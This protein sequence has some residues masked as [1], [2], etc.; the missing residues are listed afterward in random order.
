MSVY[1]I[2]QLE[3]LGSL[4]S[5]HRNARYKQRL[6]QNLHVEKELGHGD[7]FRFNCVFFLK[8]NHSGSTLACSTSQSQVDIWNPAMGKLLHSLDG[9]REIVTS[10][11]WLKEDSTDA[12]FSASLDK[13]IRLWRH[14]KPVHVLR[15]HR[16][17]IRSLGLSR[18]NKTLVSGCVSSKILGWDV[19]SCK[20]IFRLDHAEHRQGQADLNTVNSL[21]FSHHSS[22]LFASG[23]RDG[24]AMLWDIRTPVKP[25]LQFR[26]HKNKLNSVCFSADDLHLLTS[27]R[28]SAIRLWDIRCTPTS[29]PL[30][31]PS[32]ISGRSLVREYSDHLCSG[33]NVSCQF[34]N[35]DHQ[36]LTGSE[37]KKVYIYDVLSGAATV[38]PE[39]P[40]VTHAVQATDSGVELMLATSAV[41]HPFIRLWTPSLDAS[42]ETDMEHQPMH[43]DGELSPRANSQMNWR[44]LLSEEF[45]SPLRYKEA[46]AESHRH[47]LEEV[48]HKYGDLLLQT[49]HRHNFPLTNNNRFP[50]ALN[51]L[52]GDRQGSLLLKM[53][54][55]LA[56]DFSCCMELYRRQLLQSFTEGSGSS[57]VDLKYIR[58]Y[59]ELRQQKRELDLDARLAA[60][61]IISGTSSSLSFDET[62]SLSDS[63]ARLTPRASNR[64]MPDSTVTRPTSAHAESHRALRQ[65][66]ITGIP[67][68]PPTVSGVEGVSASVNLGDLEDAS[69]FLSS[70]SSPLAPVHPFMTPPLVSIPLS[71]RSSSAHS[72]PTS[73]VQRNRRRRS[74]EDTDDE[75]EE[76]KTRHLLHTPCPRSNRNPPFSIQT[77]LKAQQEG[78]ISSFFS[79]EVSSPPLLHSSPPSPPLSTFS[80][81]RSSLLRPQPRPI[82]H[83]GWANPFTVVVEPD[84]VG[85]VA[86]DIVL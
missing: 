71:S 64:Y 70:S 72:S 65:Y 8:F 59:I 79:A 26:A 10:I 66:L 31:E 29:E 76:S 46:F 48:M 37:D 43:V 15:D 28:D 75:K 74:R 38:L 13:T 67:Q 7:S 1:K 18:D 32:Q 16:D 44:Q 36:I 6:V 86:D 19:P 49:F 5:N 11:I 17:W 30:N 60:L 69:G 40:A 27:G 22:F 73:D 83:A 68:R 57:C 80:H 20:V 78:Q 51:R 47:A 62:E 82:E 25:V 50:Y 35:E 2:K 85:N 52:E 84:S 33:Y 61:S 53:V 34:M 54:R 63:F 58:R 21:D 12:F 23:S 3:H 14:Y 55:E 42:E 77:N 41:D 56:E 81:Y 45:V 24:C 39:Q 9:H 4:P